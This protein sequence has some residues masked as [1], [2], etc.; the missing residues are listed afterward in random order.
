MTGREKPAFRNRRRNASK[1]A[2]LA[3]VLWTLFGVFGIIRGPNC[4]AVTRRCARLRCQHESISRKSLG[5][6]SAGCWSAGSLLQGLMRRG[7]N[8]RTAAHAASARYGTRARA[9]FC[10]RV[11]ATA[12]AARASKAI[13]DWNGWRPFRVAAIV[14]EARDVKSFYFTPVDGRPLSPFAPGQYLTFRL[15][16]RG[17]RGAAGAMLFALG[18]A[19]A[20]LLPG[21]D[22]AHRA[23]RR[24]G[25]TR[26]PVAAA[27][28]FTSA[29]RWAT[30]WTFAR[31]PARFSSIRW[32][33]SRSCW[34]GRHRHHAAGE[35]AGSDRASRPAA[36]RVRAVRLSQ[37]RRAS[38][39]GAT[40]SSLRRRIRK[41]DCT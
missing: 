18:S 7:G 10:R 1:S 11:E 36:R 41:S 32:P 17:E 15:A 23:R 29:C 31:R 3:A 21:D 19:A 12:R 4:R 34:S 24:I 22:Q 30:C 26:R 14:D 20:G 40:G 28:I 38:V 8:H 27:A 33:T 5:F 13:P 16:G 6:V 37:R 35:H 9:E 39:Q 2:V 25:R